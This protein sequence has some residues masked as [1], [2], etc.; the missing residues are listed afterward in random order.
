MKAIIERKDYTDKQVTGE[1]TLY[2]GENVIFTCKTL[3]LPWRDNQNRISCI[4]TGTYHVVDR[5]SPTFGRSYHVKSPGLNDVV[6]RNWILIH[7]GNYHTQIKG[8]IL[9][10]R[11]LAHINSDGYLDV[12]SSRDTLKELLRLAPEGFEME[13][14]GAQPSYDSVTANRAA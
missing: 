11:A 10:G 7:P 9:V 14:R 8:C 1:F 2:D 6:G 4:P 5:V 13:I 12:T 3:E